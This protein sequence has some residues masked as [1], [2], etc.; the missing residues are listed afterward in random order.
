MENLCE[1][2]PPN[3][4]WA[5]GCHCGWMNLSLYCLSLDDT[6]TS[7]VCARTLSL[8]QTCPL[9]TLH[10]ISEALESSLTLKGTELFQM[11]DVFP[12]LTKLAGTFLLS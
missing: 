9:K 2:V 12:T 7:C 10:G 4:N 11:P 3:W 5:P 1:Q 6:L 8:S